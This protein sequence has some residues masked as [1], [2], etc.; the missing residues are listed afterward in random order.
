DVLRTG[1]TD[2]RRTKP[3]DPLGHTRM[4]EAQSAEFMRKNAIAAHHANDSTGFSGTLLRWTNEQGGT[5]YTLSL[6]S[7]EFKPF[8]KGGDRVRDA[9]LGADGEIVTSGF[10][11]GQLAAL[12]D[13]Y[14][15]E[16]LPIVGTQKINVTGYSLGGHLATVFT[17][18]HADA[19]KAAY[20]FNGA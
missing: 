1:N 15:R 6:R 18:M 14:Q 9:L 4:P 8:D 2:T 13:F 19:V 17:E 12:E 16:V 5:E 3:E 10:A 7:T 20:V 11:I